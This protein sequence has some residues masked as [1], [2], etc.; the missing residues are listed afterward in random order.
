MQLQPYPQIHTPP[1]LLQY[2]PAAHNE[3]SDAPAHTPKPQ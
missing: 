3:H 2:D 1:A